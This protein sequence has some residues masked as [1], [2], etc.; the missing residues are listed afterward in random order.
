MIGMS[1]EK[2]AATARRSPDAFH[3]GVATSSAEGTK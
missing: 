2:P 3:W 1:I